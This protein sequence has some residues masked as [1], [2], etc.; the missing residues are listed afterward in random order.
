[1]GGSTLQLPNDIDRCERWRRAE[2]ESRSYTNERFSE[3]NVPPIG[4]RF[5]VASFIVIATIEGSQ[6][7]CVARRD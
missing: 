5:R 3:D 7:I 2:W 4:D 6:S 1:V